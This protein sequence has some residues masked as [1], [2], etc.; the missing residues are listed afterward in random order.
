MHVA[1]RPVSAE[2]A[3]AMGRRISEPQPV[4]ALL[5]KHAGLIILG[6]PGAGK[7]TFLKYLALCLALGQDMG[8]GERLPVLLPLSAYANRLAQRDV[9]LAEFIAEYYQGLVGRELPLGRLLATALDK[10]QA[11]LL[12][13]GLDEVRDA[14]Q[15]RRVVERVAQFFSFRQQQGNKFILTSRIVGYR[16]VQPVVTGVT[17]CTLVDFD[18]AEMEAFVDKWTAALEQAAQANPQLAAQ[19][20]AREKAELLAAIRNNPGV[21]RLAANPLLLTIL[22]LMKRQGV[23]L[24]ERRVALYEQYVQTLLQHWN[25]ARGL[26]GPGGQSLDVT[27]TV[28]VLAPLALWMHETSPGVGLVKE[29]ALRRQLAT[30]C[31]ERGVTEPEQAA[32]HFLRDA[33]DYAGLLVERGQGTFGFIHLTFQEYLAGVAVAQKGQTDPQPVV[34]ALAARLD[35]DNWREV[36]RLAVGYLGIVQQREEAASAVAQRLAAQRVGQHGQAEI[37]AGEAV[38]DVWPG[39]VTPACRAAIQ[40]ALQRAMEDD[41][42]V[43]P[44][45][46]A[47]VGTTL[48]RVG[49]PRPGVA[50]RTVDDLA[51]MPFCF[52][53]KGPFWLGSDEDKDEQPAAELDLP[54]DY[55]LARYPV[56]VTQFRLFVEATGHK[57]VDA[58]SLRD[59]PNRPVR[60]LTWHEALA[61][62]AGWTGC[63]GISCPSAAV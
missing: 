50:P 1:G 17:E 46:R 33:R 3:E 16:E 23:T 52:V 42:R 62:A 21:R 34:D 32:R 39:G 31:Q 43:P 59:A 20:A 35:D 19:A 36:A 13:D 2:E 56:T 6:D 49:D 61:F 11:L 53:P 5:Q 55:W 15:R 30:I 12:L 48:A 60:W 37:V 47:R 45:Q 27:A 24:P 4:L 51:Q 25:L 18:D 26:D 57:P 38:A 28:K 63:G 58:N 14:G 8:L 54:Y 7:T 40:Q 41:G 22:A 9:A 10:G 29:Q 44:R